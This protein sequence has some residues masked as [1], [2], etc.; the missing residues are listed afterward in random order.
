MEK[1]VFHLL[2]GVIVA[3]CGRAVNGE[4]VN[5]MVKRGNLGRCNRPVTIGATK[6]H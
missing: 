1:V 2:L 5:F 6:G 3:L 4:G